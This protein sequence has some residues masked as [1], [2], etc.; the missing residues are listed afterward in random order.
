MWQEKNRDIHRPDRLT[1]TAAQKGRLKGTF[2][3][4][5]LLLLLLLRDTLRAK[6]AR[7]SGKITDTN[8]RIVFK[9]TK[10]AKK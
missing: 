1:K 10:L 5:L 7:N 4:F 3:F 6:I 8:E 2:Y 9:V